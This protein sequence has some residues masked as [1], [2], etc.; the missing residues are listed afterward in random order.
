VIRH[1]LP[2]EEQRA[3]DRS[4]ELDIRLTTAGEYV[5]VRAARER[6]A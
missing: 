6:I 5:R 3:L 2:R 4:C 1:R